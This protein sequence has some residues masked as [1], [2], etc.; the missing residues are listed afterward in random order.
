MKIVP[1][2]PLRVPGKGPSVIPKKEKFF[3]AS[4]DKNANP[5][6]WLAY[7]SVLKTHR[8]F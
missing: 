6:F 2:K 1:R 7:S 8:S 3:R 5:L 4:I